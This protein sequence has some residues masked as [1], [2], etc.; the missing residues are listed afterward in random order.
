MLGCDTHNSVPDP[1]SKQQV[2]DTRAMRSMPRVSLVYGCC[3]WLR[4]LPQ[5]ML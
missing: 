3:G 2:R 1:A 4:P 5:Q